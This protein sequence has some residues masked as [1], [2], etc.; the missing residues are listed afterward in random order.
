MIQL[1]KRPL[2]WDG[3]ILAMKMEQDPSVKKIKKIW[4][5]V[6][7]YNRNFWYDDKLYPT[8]YLNQN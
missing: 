7:K 1:E 5:L 4:G 6:R 8:I 3:V 2:W